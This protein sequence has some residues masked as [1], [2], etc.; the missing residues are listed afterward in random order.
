MNIGLGQ[1]IFIVLICFILFGDIN[2][3]LI[4]LNTFFQKFKHFLNGYK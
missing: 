4:N 2:N 3:M 1:I